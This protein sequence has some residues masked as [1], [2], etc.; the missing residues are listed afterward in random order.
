[1]V[2]FELVKPVTDGCLTLRQALN[3]ERHAD[4]AMLVPELFVGADEEPISVLLR[5]EYALEAILDGLYL[6]LL[7]HLREVLPVR[8]D[9]L[10][11]V[12]GEIVVLLGECLYPS[13]NFLH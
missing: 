1:M 6:V 5:L 7:E 11:K 10:K 12:L 13:G 2:L 4:L 3:N 8:S 9:F